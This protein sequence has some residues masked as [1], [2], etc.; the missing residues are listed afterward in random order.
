M[1]KFF[2]HLTYKFWIFTRNSSYCCSPS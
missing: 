1:I 2:E